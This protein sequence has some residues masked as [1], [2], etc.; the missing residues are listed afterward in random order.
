MQTTPSASAGEDKKVDFD[1]F[2]ALSDFG[3]VT[4]GGGGGGGDGGGGGG[5]GGGSLLFALCTGVG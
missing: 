1:F 2:E 5:G 3:V 4:A